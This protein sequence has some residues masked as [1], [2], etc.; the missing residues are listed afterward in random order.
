MGGRPVS[1]SNNA[2]GERLMVDAARAGD[3]GALSELYTL[4]FPRVY[5][6]ILARTGNSYDA[7]DLAEEVFMRV[8]EAIERFQWRE[9]PFSA[10]LFRIAHNAV[11]SQRRKDGARG[12]S[13]P[14]SEGLP[15]DG[16]GPE[17]LVEMRL[18]LLQ[19]REAAEKLP[20]AQ[21]RVIALRFGAGLSVAETARAMNKGEG[22]VKVIQHKAIAKLREIVRQRPVAHEEE[23]V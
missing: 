5:R 18:A 4:Y 12:R 10:W 15:L 21:R 20:E 6:Y 1:P 7:E 3:Q 23:K 8:L 14:L 11:I 9:A 22:N 19:G 17:E 2:H 16:Q 13:S